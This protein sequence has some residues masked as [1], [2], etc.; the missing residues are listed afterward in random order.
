MTFEGTAGKLEEAGRAFEEIVGNPN[1]AEETFEEIVGKPDRVKEV[2][3]VEVGKLVVLFSDA[4]DMVNEVDK[5]M[6]EDTDKDPDDIDRA[7]E[8]LALALG[9]PDGVELWSPDRSE[10]LGRVKGGIVG[11]E[12]FAEVVGSPER[13]A[14]A[15]AVLFEENVGSLEGKPPGKV[16]LNE[17][18]GNVRELEADNAAEELLLADMV[19]S[20]DGAEPVGNPIDEMFSEIVGNPEEAVKL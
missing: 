10:P 19:G 6:F 7:D 13:D 20:P 4:T 5:E 12:L 18:V 17:V 3:L 15:I 16:L 1:E 11:T 9:N 14:V 8:T 2:Y